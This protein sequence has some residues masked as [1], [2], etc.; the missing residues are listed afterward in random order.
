MDFG[1]SLQVHSWYTVVY[2]L[3]RP[4]ESLLAGGMV[5]DLGPWSLGSCWQEQYAGVGRRTVYRKAEG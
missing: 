4:S 2:S 5:S 3:D 1:V